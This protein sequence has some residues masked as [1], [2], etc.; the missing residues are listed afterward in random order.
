M[1]KIFN[2]LKKGALFCCSYLFNKI[3]GCLSIIKNKENKIDISLLTSKQIEEE[4]KRET[5][6]S[7]YFRL[8]KS[9]IYALIIIG[10]FSSLI[11]TFFMPVLQISTTS[12]APKYNT[13]DYVISIKTK[14]LQRGDVIAFYHGNK[15]LVKRVI[16]KSGEWV[17]IDEDGNV[18]VDGV[19]LQE[20]YLT[21]KVLGEYDI[22]FPYQV[23]DGQWFVLSDVRAE[24]ID[25]RN[26]NIG[27]I[28]G[29]D[30][31]GKILFKIWNS[32]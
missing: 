19:K 27:C 14:N 8:L 13:G 17:L 15:I 7:K 3:K 22:K 1:S 6:K 25:S 32:N 29:E 23:P 30:I 4:L 16:A 26:S 18:Y 21:N 5:Y 12:M 2:K 9:T 11:A 20:P 31:I 24:S 10:A 28:S